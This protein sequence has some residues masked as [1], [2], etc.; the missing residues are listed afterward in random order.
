MKGLEFYD[1][2]LMTKSNT[3]P[4]TSPS[5]SSSDNDN[6]SLKGERKKKSFF[7][8]IFTKRQGRDS[9]DEDSVGPSDGFVLNSYALNKPYHESIGT[10]CIDS[11][12]S[13]NSKSNFF[14]KPSLKLLTKNIQNQQ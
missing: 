10:C 12:G 4:N 6:N 9:S 5:P 3:S 1:Q 7:P 11:G 8:R 14:H 2:V 13:S